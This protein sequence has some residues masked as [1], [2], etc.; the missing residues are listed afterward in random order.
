MP[1]SGRKHALLIGINEYPHLA[2][3]AQ[4]RGCVNDVRAL[5][6]LLRG[7]F[8]FEDDR[9]TVL[10]DAEATRDGI[11]GALDALAGR[12]EADDV[13]VLAYA[14]HGSQITDVDGDE[15][16][17]L[18][19]T[20]VPYDAVRGSGANRD[21]TD[22]ELHAWILRV[23]ER[24]PYLTL[25]FDCCHS[26]TVTRDGFGAR[27][28]SLE[29]D[30][31]PAAALGRPPAPATTRS[32]PTASGPSGWLPLSQ[33][34]VLVAG[35]RD[36][37]K[38]H[39]HA[40]PETGVTNGALTFFLG[41]A[42]ADA[43]PG[44]TYR[45][46]FERVRPAVTSHYPSQHPQMEGAL[47]R[48]VF[49][50]RD[51]EPMRYVTVEA[52]SG[53]SVTLGAGAAHGLSVGSEWDVYPAGTKETEGADPLGRVRLAAVGAVSSEADLFEEAADG[54]VEAGARAVEAAHAPDG[55]VL[56]VVVRAPDAD[57]DRIAER[58]EDSSLL[59]VVSDDDPADYAVVLV[60]AR[61]AVSEG[62]PVPQLGAVAEPTWVVVGADGR[63]ASPPHAA[64]EAGVEATVRENLD[65]LA[66]YG[67]A[68]ALDDPT[69]P[70][71][72]CVE[73][74]IQRQ[75]PG[76]GWVDAEPEGAGGEVVFEE[77][78]RMAFTVTNRHTEPVFV[79]AL[80]F[81]L[82]YAVQPLT[83]P[84]ASEALA[85]GATQ[86]V[87][88]PKGFPLAF[89][90]TFPFVQ[91]P[92]EGA[93]VEGTETL[94]VFA[95]T[96]PADFS[97]L[98]QG[99]VRSAGPGGP[100]GL[101]AL[102]RHTFNSVPMRDIVQ[103]EPD[104][105]EAWTAVTRTFVLRRT[106]QG[107]PL[108]GERDVRLGLA[109]V[110]TRGL[111][112]RARAL[113]PPSFSARTRS[114]EQASD[115]L[116]VVLG[117]EH[118]DAR[119]TIE[120]Q[121]ARTRSLD[122]EPEIEVEVPEVPDAG[123]FLLYTDESGV[124]TW[125]FAEPTATRSL[126]GVGTHT[127]VIRRAEPVPAGGV[128][129]RGVLGAVGK[130]LIKLLVFPLLDP[131]VG[132]VGDYYAERWE[133]V[134]RPYGLRPFTPDDYRTPDAPTLGA[135]DWDRLAAGRALLLVHGT[136]SRAHSAFGGLAPETVAEL[137]RRYGGRVFAFDHF[138]LSH[139]PEANV[140]WFLDRVP[141]GAAL[142]LDVVCHSRGG[143]VSRM[144]AEKQS[145]FS[146]GS[147]QLRVGKVVFVASPN[148]GTHL[149][150]AEHMGSLVDTYTNLLNFI[151]D[152]PVTDVLDGVV[153]VAKQ[154]AVGA[155]KGLE[156]LQ[157]MRPDG[158]FQRRLNAANGRGDTRYFALGADFA[159]AE[160]GFKRWA[161]ER[162]TQSVFGGDNDLVVPTASVY[163]AN[164]SGFFPIEDRHVFPAEDGVSHT[165]FFHHPAAQE[166]MLAWL[167]A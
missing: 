148:A 71:R 111:E 76:G 149:A 87:G 50:V 11:L 110:R 117:A 156:G 126:D 3:S 147:R 134:R 78:E 79:Y 46:V 18:D 116:G 27:T 67:V 112:G 34:Y 102:L 22:D 72:G 129:T 13:V 14:G 118:V 82:A 51:V 136:F 80:D 63:L 89:P 28:R 48:E 21:I 54:A 146:L 120:I 39:E 29:P 141:D 65:K 115:A 96:Q 132:R 159:P 153:T 164:G 101:D 49:G 127:F 135:A 2:A 119:G 9:V 47:D 37:Q 43:A 68:L 107:V 10:T 33:R 38:S 53:R 145:E 139:D 8:G 60:P 36:E 30:T 88:Y 91:E 81:G 57:C 98:R 160:P 140:R 130:K 138:T 95:T 73:V 77:G 4:L 128:G 99:S 41:R 157:S 92:G 31:R 108:D 122:A 64:S 125:Q 109:T 85:P 26:G 155:L 35:C 56:R 144:L 44:T 154:L 42:L 106:A 123:Q 6:T 69:S 12:V 100:R 52:R 20:L 151:P 40:D 70:L 17:G 16:D 24:T 19:E 163:E 162:L 103:D 84:G 86:R 166:K 131:V 93:P 58:I 158:D 5:A 66:R 137:H 150:D 161:L 152:N 83:M 75:G 32:A 124:T 104:E 23:T 97:T 90:K 167:G 74:Q 113:P 7:R 15:P 114:V 133:G 59:A 1:A 165:A 142:D 143:L 61:D 45:D 121:E 62:D 25:L 55:L 94:K 105:D